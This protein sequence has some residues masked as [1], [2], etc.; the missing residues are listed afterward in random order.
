MSKMAVENKNR[1]SKTPIRSAESSTLGIDSSTHLQFESP[2]DVQRSQSYKN[3]NEIHP[4]IS[5]PIERMILH[6]GLAMFHGTSVKF[7]W[8]IETG[9][10]VYSLQKQNNLIMINNSKKTEKKGCYIQNK[11]IESSIV[12]R[13]FATLRLLPFGD[14]VSQTSQLWWSSLISCV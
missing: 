1:N 4:T 9:I 13:C 7:L 5:N 11:S 3:R 2:E 8:N 12:S 14:R 6:S 10:I